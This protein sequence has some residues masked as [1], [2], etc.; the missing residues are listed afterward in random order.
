[1]REGDSRENG[2]KNGIP[3]GFLSTRESLFDLTRERVES[4]EHDFCRQ[5]SCEIGKLAWDTKA[6]SFLSSSSS[7]QI[8]TLLLTCTRTD[9]R[10]TYRTELT[11]SI[12]KKS[13]ES[14]ERRRK[15]KTEL[16]S[17]MAG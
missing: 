13:D 2:E 9:T 6:E 12:R 7:L 15:N 17:A 8:D 5:C 14:N 1:M 10:F 4:R 16:T 3:K 11:R